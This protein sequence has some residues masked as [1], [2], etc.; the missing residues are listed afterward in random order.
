MNGRAKATCPG[1]LELHRTQ[2]VAGVVHRRGSHKAAARS[3]LTNAASGF[4]AIG[5][6]EWSKRCERELQRVG[7]PAGLAT[8]LTATEQKI[9]ELAALGLTNRQVAERAFLSPKIV[10]ANVARVY[11]KLGITLRAE[12]VARMGRI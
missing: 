12:L 1:P 7:T 8:S 5:A 10:E 4:A 2:L 9:A 3:A 6:M 11:R